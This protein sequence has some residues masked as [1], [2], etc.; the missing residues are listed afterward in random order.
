VNRATNTTERHVPPFVHLS[1]RG[2]LQLRHL[3]YEGLREVD[4]I[5]ERKWRGKSHIG[6]APAFLIEMQSVF[7][8]ILRGTEL[9]L[10]LLTCVEYFARSSHKKCFLL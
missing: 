2:L 4:H 1:A 10:C 7:Q 5:L 9:C 3:R 6:G 8:E